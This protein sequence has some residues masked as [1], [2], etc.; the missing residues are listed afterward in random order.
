MISTSFD[1]NSLMEHLYRE[2][3]LD[4]GPHCESMRLIG[5]EVDGYESAS[6]WVWAYFVRMNDLCVIFRFD[7]EALVPKS[8]YKSMCVGYGGIEVPW[9]HIGDGLIRVWRHYK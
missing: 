1:V 5:Y 9:E 6:E 8:K 4:I 3:L 7:K 2:R